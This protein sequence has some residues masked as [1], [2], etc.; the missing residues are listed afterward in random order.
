MKEY[1]PEVN[2]PKAKETLIY[3]HKA[4]NDKHTFAAGYF[5]AIALYKYILYLEERIRFLCFD[6]DYLINDDYRL[7]EL[8]GDSCQP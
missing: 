4:V 1:L 2:A 3:L 5:Q 7:L 8:I 6:E